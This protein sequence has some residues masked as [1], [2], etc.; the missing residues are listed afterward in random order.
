MLDATKDDVPDSVAR[1]LG[2]A[3]PAMLSEQGCVVGL[4]PNAHHGAIRLALLRGLLGGDIFDDATPELKRF[5]LE[6]I[7]RLFL[8]A[9]YDL[10]IIEPVAHPVFEPSALLPPLDRA[11]FSDALVREI[12][13]DSSALTVQFVVGARPFTDA[14]ADPSADLQRV[15]AETRERAVARHANIVPFPSRRDE[16]SF[17]A[18]LEGTRRQ[19][20]LNAAAA[21]RAAARDR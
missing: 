17:S 1:I 14:N 15:L 21:S 16:T 4:I 3:R 10:E 12:E 11:Q 6:A 20:A 2:G 13:A 18:E 7:C 19:A 5:T 8:Q 9:G